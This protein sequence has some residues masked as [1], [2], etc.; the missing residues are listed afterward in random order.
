MIRHGFVRSCQAV[1]LPAL[2]PP[3][4]PELFRASLKLPVTVHPSLRHLNLPSLP[5]MPLAVHRGFPQSSV[6]PRPRRSFQDSTCN[7][8]QK[9]FRRSSSPSGPRLTFPVFSGLSSDLL[10]STDISPKEPDP[11][12]WIT[13]H[14]DPRGSP[15]RLLLTPNPAAFPASKAA[16]PECPL[17]LPFLTLTWKPECG[18]GAPPDLISH[19]EFSALLPFSR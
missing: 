10:L 11:P 8:S 12:P 9:S 17:P 2:P 16:S 19:C 13:Q 6:F 15:P 3:A 14:R 18:L 7:P 1:F 5:R 4:S